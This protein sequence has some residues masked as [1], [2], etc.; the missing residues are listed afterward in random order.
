[1]VNRLKK[2]NKNLKNSGVARLN[3]KT[4]NT[5]SSK[6]YTYKLKKSL[7]EA[8]KLL[9]YGYRPLSRIKCEKVKSIEINQNNFNKK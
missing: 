8:F 1:M 4:V 3:Q 5:I 7:I 2:D 9:D 6:G